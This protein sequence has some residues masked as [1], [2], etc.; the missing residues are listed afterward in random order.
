[1]SL[2]RKSMIR[3]LSSLLLSVTVIGCGSGKPGTV[4][5]TGVVTLDGNPVEKA[6]V[7][8]MPTDS[9]SGGLPASGATDQKG[10][11][12]LKTEK[13]GPGA[14][15]GSYRATV[16]KKETSGILAGPNGLDGGIAPGGIKEKWIIPKKYSMP[17]E[18]GLTVEV[19]AGMEPL[20]FDLKSK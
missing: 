18:S 10:Q 11:F 6:A 19:K 15:P 16:I 17:N 14:L 8:L 1:M 7:M 13:I 4:Q 20:S 2:C 3:F 5:V 12:T 9:K